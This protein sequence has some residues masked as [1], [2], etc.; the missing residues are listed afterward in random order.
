MY[1]CFLAGFQRLRRAYHLPASTASPCNLGLH[2]DDRCG[3]LLV[4]N[5]GVL[6]SANNLRT[7]YRKKPPVEGFTMEMSGKG[8][9]IEDS[10]NNLSEPV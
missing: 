9:G 10:N 1:R 7:I 4:L 5:C 2:G 8:A 6:P 3:R